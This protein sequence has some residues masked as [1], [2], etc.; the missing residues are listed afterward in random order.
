MTERLISEQ[1]TSETVMAE[2]LLKDLINAQKTIYRSQVNPSKEEREVVDISQRMFDGTLESIIPFFEA[3]NESY[4]EAIRTVRIFLEAKHLGVLE[5]VRVWSNHGQ[6]KNA[7]HSAAV[8]D[9]IRFLGIK[10]DAMDFLTL[11]LPLYERSLTS[12][13]QTP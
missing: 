11:G 8:F 2:R 4:A 12:A 3:K 7:R 9:Q 5:A 10:K 1:V 13:E 6:I